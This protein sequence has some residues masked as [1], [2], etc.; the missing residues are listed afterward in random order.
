MHVLS[1]INVGCPRNIDGTNGLR[2]EGLA[3][4]D[5]TG[6][7][8]ANAGDVNGDGKDDIIIGAFK[9]TANGNATAG[10]SFVIFGQ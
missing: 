7:S 8:V 4:D 3:I 9:A 5:R 1:V 2:I 10:Q 6:Q